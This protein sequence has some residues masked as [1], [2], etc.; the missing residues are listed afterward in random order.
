[1]S[2]TPEDL[3]AVGRAVIGREL[4][5]PSVTSHWRPDPGVMARL[6]DLH[7][8]AGLLAKTRPDIF[9]HP[10]VARALEQMLLHAMV[11]CLADGAPVETSRCN[12]RHAATLARLE[13]ELVENCDRPLYLAEICTAIG[14][15]E[16]SLRM[17]C[18]DPWAWAPPLSLAATHD[19]GA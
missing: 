11:R 9:A 7:D 3:A 12:R 13:N 16:R 14:V 1:M 6:I 4:T 2:L 17:C 19:T 18:Q 15:S 8:S 5:V 10:E